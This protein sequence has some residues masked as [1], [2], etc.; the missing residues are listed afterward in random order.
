[1]SKVDIRGHGGGVSTTCTTTI[2]IN[3]CDSL[4]LLDS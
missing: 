3:L 1:M 4:H 2:N